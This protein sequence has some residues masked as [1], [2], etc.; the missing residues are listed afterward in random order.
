MTRTLPWLKGKSTS[1]TTTTTSSKSDARPPPPPKRRRVSTPLGSDDGLDPGTAGITTPSTRR[2]LESIRTPS[3]SPPPAPPEHNLTMREGLA[4]DDIWVMV[5]D[6]FYATAQNYTQHLHH[7]EYQR[8]KQAAKD[9]E[10][11]AKSVKPAK[12]V[13]REDPQVLEAHADE[14]EADDPWLG[15]EL[16]GLM[17]SP[18]KM[19]KLR[20]RVVGPGKS[21]TRASKGLDKPRSQYE[22]PPRQHEWSRSI[23][24]EEEHAPMSPTSARKRWKADRINSRISTNEAHDDEEGDDDLDAPLHASSRKAPTVQLMAA[25]CPLAERNV[26]SKTTASEQRMRTREDESPSRSA[27]RST[28]ISVT[29]ASHRN[30]SPAISK[31]HVLDETESFFPKPSTAHQPSAGSSVMARR[32]A[33]RAAKAKLEDERKQQQETS[34]RDNDEKASFSSHFEIPTFL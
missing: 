33:E 5:E 21:E 3:T 6:E 17:S 29:S 18:R 26:K 16:A 28:R 30:L 27:P 1:A 23:G 19:Q 20:A 2:L 32:R 4:E 9:R 7:A 12:V 8:L 10:H 34:E 11:K 25:E 31:A 14:S 15:T 22:S 24:D 13:R